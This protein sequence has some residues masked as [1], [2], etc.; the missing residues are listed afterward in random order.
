MYSCVGS[1]KFGENDM[2][3]EVLKIYSKDI[4]QQEYMDK[5]DE[6]F[7]S[8]ALDKIREFK[9]QFNFGRFQKLFNMAVK[10]YVCVYAFRNELGIKD[11]LSGYNDLKGAHCP[12]DSTILDKIM[13]E[14]KKYSE[15]KKCKWTQMT[16]SAKYA[17]I[18]DAIQDIKS[19]E[20]A[21]NLAYDFKV[22]V[23]A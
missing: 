6:I 5:L 8:K 19:A 16:D 2:L 18:Q 10:Y 9:D 20:Q 4:N 14:D 11:V 17:E 23:K 13:Q 15:F 7:R 1:D 12:I 21:S 3:Q 22:W